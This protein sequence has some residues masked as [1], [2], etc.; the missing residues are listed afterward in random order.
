VI[1]ILA[2]EQTT[3]SFL[4][5][6]T[7]DRWEIPFGEWI[8]QAV[9]WIDNNL[10]TLLD[11]IEW[12]FD[13]LISAIVDDFLVPISWFWVVLGMGLI[14]ALV[15]NFKVGA[16]VAV[17]L[18]VCGL[19]GNDYWL[20]T[21]RTIGFIGVA[22]F[23]CVII[24][25][26][27]GVAAGRSD[28]LWQVT[29]PILDGM[30]VIHSFV[31]ML[32]FIF[33][34][35]I[36]EVSATMVT[37]I[38]ALPPLIRLT[39]LGIRQVP[40]DVVEAA[41]AHG[42]PE[43]RV[44][45]DVQLPLARPAIMTGINQTLLLAISMLG[46]AAIMGAGGLGRLLFRALSNQSVPLGAS[47][48]LAFFLVAV[49]LDRMSQ[50]EDTDQGNLWQRIKQAWA[51]R[52]DPEALLPE[53]GA[54][55][56]HEPTERYE[57]MRP[58]ERTM[59]LI[60]MIGGAVAAVSTFL[61]WNSN[62]GWITSYGFRADED[63]AGMSFNGLDASGGSFFGI[64]VL[65]FGLFVVAAAVTTLLRPGYGPR[66]FAS[67]GAVIGGFGA[68][69]TAGSFVLASPPPAAVDPE[70]GIGA[71]LAVIGGGVAALASILW[72]GVA[73]HSPLHPLKAGISWGRLIGAV[74]S[75][76]IVV[77]G[78]ITVW[79][80]DGRTDVVL[81][82]EDEARIAELEEEARTSTDPT[83]A[84]VIANDIANIRNQAQL[85]GAIETGGTASDGPGLGIWTMV[86]AG[87]ALL[88]NL[89]ASGLFGDDEH[90]KWL[91]SSITAG[92]GTGI[93]S[94]AFA[95]IFTFVRQA[96]P[97][98]VTGMGSFFTLMGGSFILAATMSVLREFRRSKVYDDEPAE[99]AE[100][101]AEE[102]VE[103]L[104]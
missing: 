104:V 41:R 67:D 20:E 40:G 65:I 78:S 26:P 23:L 83:D 8:D 68:L 36:G 88:T 38:F 43:W 6:S 97:N 16:F 14:A 82:P 50:R 92:L 101:A 70:L 21:A 75:V 25:I 93:T 96:D 37:M 80:Y 55:V 34:W 69:I 47:A 51:H 12:P 1:W 48:G 13:T 60:A 29:R 100:S 52:R 74:V 63:L 58:R 73:P 2:Q 85:R 39:N 57:P 103:E 84:T 4:D 89:P 19:L 27:V 11:V 46:I 87:V 90:R 53:G 81:S 94:I 98:F 62:A 28:G 22:V 64:L 10:Q 45:L 5:N 54:V 91:W 59:A 42:A 79:A 66:W 3:P 86:L 35:G 44:L 33:F 17:A 49:V 72:V 31:Y 7:L 9:D 24:G 77:A 61:T 56:E 99:A 15:R 18:T 76:L 32:P 102:P 95:W 30:Q 71:I